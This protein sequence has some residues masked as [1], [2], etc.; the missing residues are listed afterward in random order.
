MQS[1][2]RIHALRL[3][4]ILCLLTGAGIPAPAH[5][6]DL[7]SGQLLIAGTRLT[8]SP[9]AQTVPFNTP[10]IVETSLQGFDPGTGT[11]P[12]DLR[13][14][15]D[16]TGPEIDGVLRLE[17]VPNQPFR[18]PRLSLKG[19][20]VLDDIRLVQGDEL[21]AYA[22]PRSAGVLVTQVLVTRVTSRALTLDEIRNYGIVIDDDRFKAFNFTFGFAIDGK[23]FDYN[24]PIIA[25]PGGEV[26]DVVQFLDRPSLL[27]GSSGTSGFRFRP[28]QIAPF[29]LE[30]ANPGR[31]DQQSGGCL[32]VHGCQ[33]AP[34]VSLPGVI[35]FP[36]DVSL[37]NQFFSVILV[38]KNDAPEGDPLLIRDLTARV[39][40]PPGL[41]LAETEPPTLLGVPVPVHVPGADGRLGTADDLTFLVAQAEGQAEV[42]VE[43]RKRGTHVVEFDLQGVLEGFPDGELRR[44]TGKARGAVVVRDPTLGLTI[45][46]PEVVRTDE[47][48]SLLLTLSNTGNAPVNLAQVTLP[49]AGLSGAQVVGASSKTIPTLA[50]G[51]SELVEFRLRSQRT[52]R[53]VATAIR[54]GSHIDPR[55]ELSVGVGELGIPLSPDAIILPDATEALPPDLVRSALSLV[56]LGYSLATAPTASVAPDHPQISL[57]GLH[58]KVYQLGQAG[59]HVRLGEDSFDSLATLAAE[60]TG[61]RSPDW[62]WD[63]LRRRTKKGGLVGD[64]FAQ[65][66]AAEAAAS[67]AAA[68]FDRFA[69]TTAFLGPAQA[70][71]GAGSGVTVTVTSRTSGRSL[72]GSGID[73]LRVRD[74]P[75]ADLYDL[76]ASQM[77]LLAAPEAGGYRVRLEDADGGTSALH[78]LV[79][80][81]AGAL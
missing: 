4:A 54:H 64:S 14:V 23:T 42:L 79:P 65:A 60:W 20:Y 81:A 29:T 70:A 76:G 69:R 10:T 36:T 80:D 15:A 24:V 57:G 73:P 48:Y 21:L 55:F 72:A 56:G 22:E 28:P 41:R 52:G 12:T 63:D 46:H 74:L 71:L 30:L 1:A 19:Q 8:V 53:V 59:R 75:F 37:L 3:T 31:A 40:V 32:A 67:S 58:E 9:E 7:G 35:L 26:G 25:G 43:G 38:A 61:A 6:A 5:A 16:F 49:A 45:T 66:F 2:V 17:T 33:L 34:P 39:S 50:P 51:E 11:L 62:E 13:V 27:G 78:L 77:A 18:I 44:V 68:T 47:E